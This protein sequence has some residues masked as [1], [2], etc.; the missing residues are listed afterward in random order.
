MNSFDTPED[1]IERLKIYISKLAAE[2][3]ALHARIERQTLEIRRLRQRGEFAVFVEEKSGEV[4]TWTLIDADNGFW[5]T[6]CF[7]AFAL[8]GSTP[9]ENNMVYCAFCGKKLVE[10]IP[11]VEV[12]E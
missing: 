12:Q 10:V 11:P 3:A 2:N 9:K 5:E 7:N 1:Q 4:C 6:T 8:E